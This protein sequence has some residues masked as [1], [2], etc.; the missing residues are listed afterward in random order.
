MEDLVCLV[1]RGV[2]G[3]LLVETGNKNLRLPS[4]SLFKEE[5]FLASAQRLLDKVELAC[6]MFQV[7]FY[8]NA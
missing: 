6:L 3:F 4:S 2:K 8:C 7:C 5:D 1:V